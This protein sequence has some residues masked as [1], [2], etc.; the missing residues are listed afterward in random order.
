MKVIIAGGRDFN[1]TEAFFK[2]MVSIAKDIE[3]DEIVSGGAKG[4]DR[5]GEVWADY[6][7]LSLKVF[8]ADWDTYNKAA[9]HIRN[10]QMAEYADFLIAFW[11]G[12]SKGTKN[13]IENMSKLEK[14]YIIVMY[15]V[16]E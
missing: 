9:G 7:K 6:A 12:S 4:A 14:P 3:I 10:K 8:P 13:M 16:E 1:D 2:S 11:D 5:L 15:R